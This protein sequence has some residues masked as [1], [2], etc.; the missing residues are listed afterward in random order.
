M[1][2]IL[3]FVLLAGALVGA[4]VPLPAGASSD[5]VASVI[6]PQGDTTDV[7]ADITNVN[8]SYGS[9]DLREIHFDMHL[10][11]TPRSNDQGWHGDTGMSWLVDSDGD[12]LADWTVVKTGQG[13][14]VRDRAGA[15]PCSARDMSQTDTDP[16]FA[17]LS[18]Q[19]DPG[20]FGGPAELRFA[21]RTSYD[22]DGVPGDG[23]PA[24]DPAPDRGWS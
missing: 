10:N 8:G 11:V 13:I 18:V 1:R 23:P 5:Y 7:R 4:S 3:L 16:N 19:V 20:C 17:M 9:G 21:A 24:T 15:V 2:R 12:G 6:D 22:A 14:S